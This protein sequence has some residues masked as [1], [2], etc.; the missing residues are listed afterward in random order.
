MVR[1]S[2]KK[3]GEF[4]EEPIGKKAD[5]VERS[6]AMVQTHAEVHMRR[7]VRTDEREEGRDGIGERRRPFNARLIGSA[8]RPHVSEGSFGTR[9]GQ[10]VR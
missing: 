1:V 10:R 2:L 9:I 5:F 4:S 8:F 6:H 7:C 3:Y